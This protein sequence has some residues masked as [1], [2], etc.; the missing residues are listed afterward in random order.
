MIFSGVT[1]SQEPHV[2]FLIDFFVLSANTFP[3]ITARV[4]I[5]NTYKLCMAMHGV[6]VG[7]AP[8]C[9]RD[10]GRWNI[11]S[12][13]S[14]LEVYTW[15]RAIQIHISRYITLNYITLST[16]AG[17]AHL[18]SADIALHE[19]HGCP[20]FQSF[21]RCRSGPQAWNQLLASLYHM[22]CVA[23]IKCHLKTKL[24]VEA[25]SGAQ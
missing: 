9:L 10:V 16:L 19:Y 23:T 2:Y 20:R 11:I 4:F 14:A 1:T 25:H 22:D 18:R 12:V 7:H 8:T 17:G 3:V 13:P 15:L 5:R 6:A 21:L 24:F